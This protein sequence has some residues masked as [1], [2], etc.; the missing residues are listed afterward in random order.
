MI[1]IL[2]C[3]VAVAIC[4]PLLAQTESA[5]PPASSPSLEQRVSDLEAYVN[6][7]ARGAD[8]ANAQAGSKGLAPDQGTTPGS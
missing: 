1:R 6:N 5:S 4:S 3:T 8:A 2:L 7:S